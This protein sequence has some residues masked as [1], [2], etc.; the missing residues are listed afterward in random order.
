MMRSECRVL[1]EGDSCWRIAHADR[2]SVLI[3]GAAYY[4]ALRASLLKARRSVFI[5]GWDVDSRTRLVGCP[6]EADDGLPEQLAPFLTALAARHPELKIHI[7]LWDYSMIFALSREPLPQINLAWMTP[8]QISVCLDDVL[9]VGA[10][11]HTKIVVIDDAVAFCGGLDLTIRRWDTPAHDMSDPDR[12]DPA[13][14]PYRPFHDV[15]M[16]VDGE[17]AAA[18]GMLARGRWREA[19]CEKPIGLQPVGDPWPDHVPADL[20]D[21]PVGIA[22]TLPPYEGSAGVREVEA[23]YKRAIDAAERSIYIECQF[24]TAENVAADLARRMRENADLTAIIVGPNVHYSWLEEHS[25]NGGRRRFMNVLKEAG[26]LD[27]I[28]LL[29]PA[30]PDDPTEEGAMVH[31]KLMVVDDRFLR[32]GSANLSN[33]SMGMDTECDL[34]VEA[35]TDDHRKGITDIRNRLLAEHLDV[36]VET[37]GSAVGKWGS[38]LAAVEA[39][40][41]G[42]RSLRP[43]D[44][45]KV[46]EDE[47]TRT[48]GQFADPERPIETPTFL[49]DLFGGTA[50]NTSIRRYAKLFAAALAVIAM[51]LIWRYTPLS[52]LTDPAALVQWLEQLRQDLWMPL[53][54]PLVFVLAG[55]I[56][57]P[58]TVLIA[59]MGMMFTPL[60]AFAYGLGGSLVSA[61][62][63]F[64]VGR[65]IGRG[66]LRTLIGSKVNR[67]SRALSRQGI[68][69]VATLRMVPIAPFS[70]INLISGAVR[71]GTTDFFIGTVLGMTPGILAISFL[72]HQLARALSEPTGMELLL[73]GL[74]IVG[75]LLLCVGLQ[76]LASRLRSRAP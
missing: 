45:S 74:G 36:D 31:A 57:F 67:I 27:R 42:G 71:I 19:A 72:G 69:S 40:S 4:G 68:L 30:L 10:S 15:Q 6:G 22:R 13:G 61:A 43:I 25:M 29:Y 11:H 48:V 60:T 73:L 26:V 47:L 1:K 38:L 62:V 63:I 9:P 14:E 56:A 24:L 18:L 52:E 49:G 16:M 51:T 75:W 50:E 17:A 33:R 66:P 34:A 7:L 3:D 20:S 39:L 37:I 28:R 21:V 2:A 35:V 64:F 5:L 65:L 32:V 76:Y 41:G 46:S 8:E 70:V 58:V 23:L 53:F 54:I 44:L 12:V 55:L 59:V